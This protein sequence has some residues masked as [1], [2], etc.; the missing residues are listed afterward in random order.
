MREEKEIGLRDKTIS[1]FQFVLIREELE[2]G[3][4][5]WERVLEKKKEEK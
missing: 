4:S 1:A 5:K 2:C 3:Q